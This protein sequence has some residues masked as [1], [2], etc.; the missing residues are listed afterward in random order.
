MQVA[1]KILEVAGPRTHG[2][3]APGI[4][5]LTIFGIVGTLVGIIA[6]TLQVSG[7]FRRRKFK[8]A[9]EALMEAIEANQDIASVRREFRELS[10]QIEVE[11]PRQA[12]DAYLKERLQQ[13][14]LNIHDAYKEYVTLTNEMSREQITSSLD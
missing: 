6:F 1:A 8:R 2:L 5:F 4:S 14:E 13:V 12:R 9:E 3:H 11:I 10:S 7:T